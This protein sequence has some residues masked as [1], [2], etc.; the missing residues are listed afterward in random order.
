[1]RQVEHRLR[2][3]LVKVQHPEEAFSLW[4]K[5]ALQNS[6]M[7]V[8]ACE[9]SCL[10][11]QGTMCT[12]VPPCGR[13]DQIVWPRLLR[14]TAEEQSKPHTAVLAA[15]AHRWQEEPVAVCCSMH[16]H[17]RNTSAKLSVVMQQP[18]SCHGRYVHCTHDRRAGP[19]FHIHCM[20]V[21]SIWQGWR[22]PQAGLRSQQRSAAVAAATQAPRPTCTATEAAWNSCACCIREAPSRLAT[23]RLACGN[24]RLRLRHAHYRSSARCGAIVCADTSHF[25]FGLL[26]KTA[27]CCLQ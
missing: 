2:S 9:Q 23:S 15:A 25:A 18:P 1:M 5:S 12:A 27:L 14:C 13:R 16:L 24:F 3:R 17:R 11:G 8:A 6:C 20:Q 26:M 21:G 19:C 7:Q 4:E 10:P 22:K